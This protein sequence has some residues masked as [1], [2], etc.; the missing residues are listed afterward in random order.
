MT[1]PASWVTRPRV[2]TT[3]ATRLFCVPYAGAGASVF[4]SWPDGLAARTDVEVLPVQLPGRETRLKEPPEVHIPPFAEDL[5]GWLDRPYALYGHSV[6]ARIAFELCRQLRRMDA[7]APSALIVSGCPA[8]H[9]PGETNEDSSL[10]DEEFVARIRG[11]GG[12]PS[13]VFDDPELRELLLPA[14]RA[15]FTLVDHYVYTDEDPLG[16]DIVACAGDADPEALP[17]RVT[18]WE[19]HTTGRFS[20]HVLPGNH[21]FVHSEQSALLGIIADALDRC[22]S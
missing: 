5:I 15:D 3:A 19:Q 8:P 4:R 7:P 11:M 20:M 6:G 21:F 12:T 13:V 16:C 22:R 10:P 17:D 1:K 9:L 18:P 2:Q 14:M